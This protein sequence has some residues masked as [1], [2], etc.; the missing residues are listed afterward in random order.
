MRTQQIAERRRGVVELVFGIGLLWLC[1][2]AAV[3]EGIPTELMTV[4]GV[5]AVFLSGMGY[6]DI[7]SKAAA[8][9]RRLDEKREADKESARTLD[10]R[11]EAIT[12]AIQALTI[13]LERSGIRVGGGAP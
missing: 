6:A 2:T 8:A 4:G 13:A 10:D 5:T 7:R 3:G 12:D 11:L 9:H 1:T